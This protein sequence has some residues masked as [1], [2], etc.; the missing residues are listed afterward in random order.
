MILEQFRDLITYLAA[1]NGTGQHELDQKISTG[2]ISH[3]DA[4]L[5]LYYVSMAKLHKKL[6][7][8]EQKVQNFV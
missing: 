5:I 2:E 7:I 6:N 3:E 8:V 1:C 4:K